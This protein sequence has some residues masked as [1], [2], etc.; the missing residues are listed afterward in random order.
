MAY[1]VEAGAQI[2][3]SLNGSV[4][5]KAFGAC[6]PKR[7]TVGL[8]HVTADRICPVHS[9]VNAECTKHGQHISLSMA[10]SVG[11][12]VR[13]FAGLPKSPQIWCNHPEPMLH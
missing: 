6:Q 1:Q 4:S 12:N 9:P 13:R 5:V 10:Q 3:Y 2:H 8:L 7:G 11:S